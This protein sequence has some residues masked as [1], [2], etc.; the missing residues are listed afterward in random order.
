MAKIKG[1]ACG[2]AVEVQ[3]LDSI[4]EEAKHWSDVAAFA[5]QHGRT[6]VASMADQR[7]AQLGTIM[8]EMR[9]D[10]LAE[11]MGGDL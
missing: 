4:I 2:V 11:M 7:L 6:D 9:P 1:R 10:R 5:L 8:D 3:M